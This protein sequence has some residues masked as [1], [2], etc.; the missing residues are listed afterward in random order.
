MSSASRSEAID[1][2]T[3]SL[4]DQGS[5][6]AIRPHVE[7]AIDKLLETHAISRQAPRILKR[8]GGTAPVLLPGQKPNGVTQL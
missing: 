4:V 1:I 8:S 3:E 6:L 7:Q 5:G 2:V